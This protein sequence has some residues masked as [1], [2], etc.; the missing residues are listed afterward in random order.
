KQ[1]GSLAALGEPCEK[2]QPGF[3]LL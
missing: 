1:D 3:S 2:I